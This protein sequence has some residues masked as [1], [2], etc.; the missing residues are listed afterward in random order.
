MATVRLAKTSATTWLARARSRT[1]RVGYRAGATA[2]RFVTPAARVDQFRRSVVPSGVVALPPAARFAPTRRVVRVM[3]SAAASEEDGETYKSPPPELAQFVERPQSPSISISPHRDQLLYTMKPPPYPFV[4]ELA[5][6]ELKLAG[7]RIDETQNSRSRMSGSTAMAIGPMP[8]S[9]AE[10][11]TYEYFTGIPEGATLNY[12]S[13][14]FDG[15]KI[16]FTT[17]FAGPSV[18]DHERAPPELWIADVATLNCRPLLPGRGLNTLFESYSWLDANTIVACVVPERRG[19]RPTRPPTPRG[20]RVQTNEGG[21]VAQARTYADLLKDSHDADLFDHFATS[22]LVK[23]DIATGEATLFDGARIHTRCDPSPDGAFVIMEE[24]HRPFSYEIPC[25][26]FPKRVWVVNRD[27]ETVREVCDLPLADAIP[28]VHNATREGPRGVNWRPDK[29]AEL[30]WTEAQD[31]GDPRVD[32]SPRDITFSVDMHGPEGAGA[33]GAKLFQTDLRYGGVSWAADGLGILYESWYK[34]RTIKAWVVDTFGRADRPPRLLYDRDYED[35]YADPG[36]PMSRRMPDGTYLLAQVEGPLPEDGW[37]PAKTKTPE[38]AAEGGKEATV[39]SPPGAVEWETGVTL[40][41]EGD[42]ASETGDKPFVD[43][44]NLDTGA[45]RRLWECSGSGGLERPGSIISDANGAPIT[46]ASLKIL[47][48]RETPSENPQYYSLEL[49]GGGEVLSPRRI[50]DFPHPH[51]ALIDPPKEILRYSRDDGVDLNA[52]LYL[53]P[54]Y[55]AE[56]DGPL[57][58]IM[59]AYPRE[60]N[61]AEAAGQLRD[62]PNRFTSIAPS[63]PLVWLARGYAVLEGPSLPIIGDA[64]NGVEPNDTYV[65]QLVAGARAAVEEVVRRGVTDPR[66]V[67]VGGHS[68]GAFMASNLL[69]HAPDLFACAVARSGAYNR[70]L[71]PFGFQSEERTLWQA[72]DVYAKMSPFNHADRIKKPILLIHGEDDTNSGTNVIQSERFFAALK[73]N[74]ADARLV[75]LP[76]ESHGTRGLESVL[77]VLAETSEFLDKHLSVEA[78]EKAAK[79]EESEKQTTVSKL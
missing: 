40:L 5:R 78:A 15:S 68:Y 41:L 76:H 24:L 53:P 66:R 33:P 36:S 61:S 56:K 12:V 16:A 17:R 48:S 8:S 44:M 75:L 58:T 7:L 69:A 10:I 45:T 57:P 71:T 52:T 20:P 9:D 18:P 27:G 37:T 14:A 43:L 72:P 1:A 35:S 51:P 64:E 31:G 28:I 73:G 13:W 22:E 49:G 70:T 79:K 3:T 19:A 6:P 11:G 54:G 4:S 29:P 25:G 50:S 67:A 32:V 60:F 62:S 39:R 26:R 77:H 59:W 2:M 74:G 46:L 34:S 21:N 55:D 42:G 38:A 63:S 23:I 47:L 30:Y 65:E